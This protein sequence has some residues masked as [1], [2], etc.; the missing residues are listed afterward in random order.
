M[1]SQ[2]T[3]EPER[4]S[5]QRGWTAE[6]RAQHKAT[7]VAFWAKKRQAEGKT[8]T[9]KTAQDAQPKKAAEHGPLSTEA[10]AQ[11][12]T[13]TDWKASVLAQLA[14]AEEKLSRQLDKVR[15]AK[16]HMEAL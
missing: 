12:T 14:D 9:P 3:R 4:A 1:T 5:G 8:T 16:V 13:W 2:T 11:E 7:M 15:A 10:T 6:K